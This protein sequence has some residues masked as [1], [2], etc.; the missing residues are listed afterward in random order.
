MRYKQRN[1]WAKFF[2]L[3][4]IFPVLNITVTRVVNKKMLS[5]KML[6][7]P[8]QFVEWTSCTASVGETF[9]PREIYK[10]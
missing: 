1:K 3:A 4:M 7:I 9:T 2:K 8:L 6:T 5:N 10:G